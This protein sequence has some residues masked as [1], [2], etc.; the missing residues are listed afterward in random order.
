VV[1]DHDFF[2]QARGDEEADLI[3]KEPFTAFA[4]ARR[5]DHPRMHVEASEVATTPL[6]PGRHREGL[7]IVVDVSA[8]ARQ[9]GQLAKAERAFQA[10][11][12]RPPAG[13]E[14][15]QHEQRALSRRTSCT[16]PRLPPPAARSGREHGLGRGRRPADAQRAARSD[17]CQRRSPA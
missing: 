17:G 10:C 5:H 9:D 4:V 2:A 14:W 3:P 16:A 12:A 13:V 8:S 1:G 7:V 11:S 6:G 15:Y